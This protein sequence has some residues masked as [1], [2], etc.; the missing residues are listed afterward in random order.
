[1]KNYLLILLIFVFLVGCEK[2]VEDAQKSYDN[3]DYK[4]AYD[5]LLKIEKKDDVG[6]VFDKKQKLVIQIIEGVKDKD[7]DLTLDLFN[8]L[9]ENNE[10]YSTVHN[11]I[12][13]N[14][15]SCEEIKDSDSTKNCIELLIGH[16]KFDEAIKLTKNT[17][18][19][20]E[21][22]KKR[23]FTKIEG[24]RLESLLKEKKFDEAIKLTKNTTYIEEK[25]KKKG[26]TKIE[27]I[28]LESLLKEKK[29]DEA[30][31]ILKD[32]T[33][34]EEK[35]KKKGLTKIVGIRLESL[36]KEKKFDEAEKLVKETKYLEEGKKP[37]GHK[38][39]V[40][41]RLQ[42]YLKEK[43]FDEAEKLVNETKYLEE[44]DKK[45]MLSQIEG[46]K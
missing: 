33:Y 30:I 24:I 3:K 19:I 38:L 6:D 8:L 37:K 16:K 18:Y 44:D 35:Y 4:S 42:N 21:K 7:H 43:K 23:G 22:Y 25:Y 2:P 5:H 45:R 17:T 10:N 11:Q 20:E 40:G 1:M 41:L 39:I 36:L 26:L 46:L 34:I 27:G 32:T 31:K 9:D 14:V 12:L 29:F 28:R 15:F 13:M